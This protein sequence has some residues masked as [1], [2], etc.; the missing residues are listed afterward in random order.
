MAKPALN[1]EGTKPNWTLEEEITGSD[2]ANRIGDST[3]FA[4]RGVGL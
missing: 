2:A 3:P 4:C 1:H